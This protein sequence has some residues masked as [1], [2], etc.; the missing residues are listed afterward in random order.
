M[1]GHFQKVCGITQECVRHEGFFDPV[2]PRTRAV[3]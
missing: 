1:D 2:N 3:G